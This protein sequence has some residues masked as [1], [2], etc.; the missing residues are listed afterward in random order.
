MDKKLEQL[1]KKNKENQI[2]NI[3]KSLLFGLSIFLLS[4][5]TFGFELLLIFWNI[6]IAV[7][8]SFISMFVVDS[9][10]YY[11]ELKKFIKK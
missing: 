9:Y 5:F 1:Q 11:K 8:L 7:I 6:V 3:K 2:N 10:Y 4:I